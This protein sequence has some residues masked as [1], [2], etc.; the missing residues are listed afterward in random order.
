MGGMGK[1]ENRETSS[2][3]DRTGGEGGRG[4]GRCQDESYETKEDVG[5]GTLDWNRNTEI[6]RQFEEKEIKGQTYQRHVQRFEA[7]VHVC[8]EQEARTSSLCHP[9]SELEVEESI[10]PFP[11]HFELSWKVS[12]CRPRTEEGREREGGFTS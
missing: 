7:I 12:L 1:E 9:S 2:E 8:I 10:F 11:R 5:G 3:G 4:Q 6:E